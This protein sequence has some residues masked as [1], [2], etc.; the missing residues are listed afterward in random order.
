MPSLETLNREYGDKGLR[1]L[2]INLK[3]EPALVA[4]FIETNGYSS[5]VLLDREGEVS[6]KYSV[7]GIPVSYLIDKAGR[8]VFKSPGF[9]DW[10]TQKMRAVVSSLMREGEQAN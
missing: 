5:T 10:N 1:V 2:L 3:E 9:V 7:Y 8:V 6:K 4:S